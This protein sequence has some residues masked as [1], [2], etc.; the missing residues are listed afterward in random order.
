[1]FIKPFYFVFNLFL[2]SSFPLCEELLST[3][4]GGAGSIL[5]TNPRH[6]YTTPTFA[7][8]DDSRSPLRNICILSSSSR[9]VVG[10]PSSVIPHKIKIPVAKS[11]VKVP[12]NKQAVKAVKVAPSPSFSTSVAGPQRNDHQRHPGGYTAPSSSWW[13]DSIKA[14]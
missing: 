3:M 10:A 11:A 2:I 13:F 14:N 12:V 5:N 6:H 7:Q 8:T 1:M 4:D 9:T